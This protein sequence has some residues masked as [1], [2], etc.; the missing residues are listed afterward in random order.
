MGGLKVLDGRGEEIGYGE[1]QKT[2]IYSLVFL[3]FI[4]SCN[5]LQVTVTKRICWFAKRL[6][7]TKTQTL[8][9]SG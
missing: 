6:K 2:K 1:K 8:Q 4:D 3:S 5:E 9:I 7:K